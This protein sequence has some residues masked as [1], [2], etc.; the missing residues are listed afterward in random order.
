MRAFTIKLTKVIVIIFYIALFA[1]LALYDEKPN[2]E[3]VKEMAHPLPEVIEPNNVCIAFIGFA[4]PKGISPYAYGAEKI[5]KLKDA[6][7]TRKITGKITNPFD[8]KKGELSFEGEIPSYSISRS[9]KMLE[10]VSKHSDEIAQLSRKNEELLKRYEM[11]Y[12]YTHY[13]EPLDCGYWCYPFPGNRLIAGAQRMKLFQMA[14][15]ANRGDVAGVLARVRKDADFWRFIVRNT[16][17]SMVSSVCLVADLHFAAEIGAHLSLNRKEM[18][19][20]QN[21]L[22]PFDQGETNKTNAIR[23]DAR[24]HI[25]EMGSWDTWI[26]KK[27]RA[28]DLNKFFLKQ[29]ATQN[30][31]YAIYRKHLPLAELSP[32]E[33]AI[34]MENPQYSRSDRIGIPFL[35]NP[36]GEIFASSSNLAVPIMIMVG[37]R[38]EGIRRLACLKVLAG[39]EKVPS[40]KMQQFLDAHAKDLGNPYTG[41]PM[42]WD[43][44][45]RS[46]YFNDL[47]LKMKPVEIFF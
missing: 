9:G 40:E 15:R 7:L 16:T 10:Y 22:K 26:P 4:S 42:M 29:N 13:T 39:T 20:L 27:E 2:D 6:L 35:Y 44:A 30:R 12:T 1:G 8:D 47:F 14:V 17:I 32:Q 24:F 45:K 19:M 46:I 38:L 34:K 23:G 25:T 28:F 21:I 41:G 31:I 36:A 18:E 37:H 11:L 33:F 5:Q 43:P 3:M